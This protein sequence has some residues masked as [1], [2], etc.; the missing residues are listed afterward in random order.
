MDGVFIAC[1]AACVVCRWRHAGRYG[2]P[3]AR[4]ERLAKLKAAPMGPASWAFL[5]IAVLAVVLIAGP[6][7]LWQRT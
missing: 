4:W 6:T 2:P 5:L 1:V 3:D 7:V